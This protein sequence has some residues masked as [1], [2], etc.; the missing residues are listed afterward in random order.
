MS[1]G[2]IVLICFAVFAYSPRHRRWH[3]Q[4]R[5]GGPETREELA[6]LRLMVDDLSSRFHRLETERDFYRDLLEPGAAGKPEKGLSASQRR[7]PR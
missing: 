1:V 4:D 5:L 3:R 2:L 6:R 7:P